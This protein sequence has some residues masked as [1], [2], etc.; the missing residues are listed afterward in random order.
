M[1]VNAV[2]LMSGSAWHS[3][4]MDPQFSTWGGAV[5]V[6]ISERMSDGDGQQGVGIWFV[7][8][9]LGSLATNLFFTGTLWEVRTPTMTITIDAFQD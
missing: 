5:G 3:T 9:G 8:S 1:M 2:S 7:E 4:R 6:I